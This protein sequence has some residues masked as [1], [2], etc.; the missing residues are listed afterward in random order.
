MELSLSFILPLYF[1]IA[2]IALIFWVFTRQLGFINIKW[3][4]PFFIATFV[5]PPVF[6]FLS[7]YIMRMFKMI[8]FKKLGVLTAFIWILAFAVLG[9]ILADFDIKRANRKKTGS[10]Y[11]FIINERRK[12]VN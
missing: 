1:V 3:Y 5:F 9:Y 4:I 12:E 6:L 7:G 8:N 2:L 10:I 11:T